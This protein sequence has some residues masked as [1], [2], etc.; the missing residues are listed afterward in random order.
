MTAG[1]NAV[2]TSTTTTTNRVS[3]RNAHR[4]L[5]S[6]GMA[7]SKR[8][9]P[10]PTRQAV[11]YANVP[12]PETVLRSIGPSAADLTPLVGF[13]LTG[14]NCAE[15]TI[16]ALQQENDRKEPLTGKQKGSVQKKVDRKALEIVHPDAAAID[17]GA[18]SI[19]Q[20]GSGPRTGASFSDVL[21][22]I[23]VR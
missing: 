4:D 13:L 18:A 15:S 16:P 21:R 14:R 10:Y 19:D 5:A 23:S 7:R 20:S 11:L 12:A 3:C 17:G 1:C 2:G 8:N 9:N 6:R 22:P